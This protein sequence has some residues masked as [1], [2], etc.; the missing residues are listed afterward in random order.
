MSRLE[1]VKSVFAQCIWVR[2]SVAHFAALDVTPAPEAVS[3][4]PEKECVK[5]S[6]AYPCLQ[7]SPSSTSNANTARLG[8]VLSRDRVGNAEV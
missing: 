1:L 4:D 2:E 5:D 6:S 7:T 8:L 3:S